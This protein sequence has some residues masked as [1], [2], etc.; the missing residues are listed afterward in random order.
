MLLKKHQKYVCICYCWAACSYFLK[1]TKHFQ[2]TF[3]LWFMY[4][5][6]TSYHVIE[7]PTNLLPFPLQIFPW[8]I[9]RDKSD[10][11]LPPPM[12]NSWQ[13]KGKCQGMDHMI[14]LKLCQSLW[15]KWSVSVAFQLT[16][17]I[18]LIPSSF[19]VG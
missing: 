5:Y 6:V 8:K 4:M 7:D 10:Y 12:F 1:A 2:Y 14:V 9:W 13:K 17:F 19:V 18:Q 3:I 16:D 11:P 15:M